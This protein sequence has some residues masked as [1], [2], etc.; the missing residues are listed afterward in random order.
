MYYEMQIER[1]YLTVRVAIKSGNTP[2]ALCHTRYEQRDIA[3]TII[4]IRRNFMY[5][6]AQTQQLR[7][8]TA[9]QWPVGSVH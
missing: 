6:K 1:Q 7:P 4:I 3:P 5:D 8:I 9:Q 2:V